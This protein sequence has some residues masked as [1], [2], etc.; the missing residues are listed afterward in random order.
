MSGSF[1]TTGSVPFKIKG[2]EQ[3]PKYSPNVFIPTAN[4][5]I[6]TGSSIYE[7]LIKDTDIY[8]MNNYVY[9]NED[10]EN[11]TKWL[12]EQVVSDSTS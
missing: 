10:A 3:K 6:N 12:F 4:M 11:K 9:K 2:I 7:Y 8:S 1:W 5:I